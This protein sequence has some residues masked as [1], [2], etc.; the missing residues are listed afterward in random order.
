MD[1]GRSVHNAFTHCQLCLFCWK[2][3]P[4][5]RVHH[6]LERTDR[7][8]HHGQSQCLEN[9]GNTLLLLEYLESMVFQYG[10]LLFTSLFVSLWT[11]TLR[12]YQDEKRLL[13]GSVHIAHTNPQCRHCKASVPLIHYTQA[14]P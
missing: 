2:Q 9:L 5:P 13:V 3:V 14:E 11:A 12:A 7:G 1:H 8:F 4:C 6:D 10:F